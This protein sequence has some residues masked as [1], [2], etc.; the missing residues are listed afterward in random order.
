[1]QTHD[2]YK[3]KVIGRFHTVENNVTMDTDWNN[4]DTSQEMLAAI[5]SWRN[6][7]MDSLLDPLEGV[8]PCCAPILAQ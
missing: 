6:Q 4:A 8:R 5:I 1:M 2:P 3:R 7:G